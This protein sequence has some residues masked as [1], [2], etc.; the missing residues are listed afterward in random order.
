MISKI[1]VP[2]VSSIVVGIP[3][4]MLDTPDVAASDAQPGADDGS[5]PRVRT[6]GYGGESQFLAQAGPAWGQRPP[7]AAN[8]MAIQNAAVATPNQPPKDRDCRTL[9]TKPDTP[10]AAATFTR[11][12][13]DGTEDHGQILN[14]VIGVNHSVQKDLDDLQVRIEQLRCEDQNIKAKLDYLIRMRTP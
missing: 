6:L 11:F 14:A 2:V 8:R 10:Y 13:T 1:L 9:V 3:C 5:P 12:Y 4:A 7:D